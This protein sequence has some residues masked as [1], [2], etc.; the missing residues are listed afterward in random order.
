M[1]S[2]IELIHADIFKAQR[3]FMRLMEAP[4][5]F[6]WWADTLITE[7]TK[8]LVKAHEENEGMEQVFKELADV[9]YVVCGFYNSMPTFPHELVD[10]ATNKRIQTILNEAWTAVCVVGEAYQIPVNI[11]GEAFAAVHVSNLSKLDENGVPIRRE[12]GKILKG[13]NYQAPDMAPIVTNWK[14]FVENLKAQ[15]TESDAETTD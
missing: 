1:Q 4:R 15:E 6:V 7:E 13:P 3:D 8:E 2:F 11:M 9:I 14:A 5:D 12:D 10:E